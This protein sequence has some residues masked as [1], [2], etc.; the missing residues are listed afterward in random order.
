MDYRDIIKQ[1]LK[2]VS[3]S[4]YAKLTDKQLHRYDSYEFRETVIKNGKSMLGKKLSEKAKQNMSNAQKNRTVNDNTKKKISKKL[5]GRKLPKETCEK[6]SKSRTG[7]K[8]SETVLQTLKE[9]QQKKCVKVSQ[10][11]L[12]GNWIKDW[13]GLK[14]A[15]ES[16][17]MKNGR[18]IQLVC[19]YYRDGLTK[20][21]KQCKG[22]IWKYTVI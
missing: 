9:A 11:N 3:D 20:G 10:F 22:F 16:F 5:L 12:D 19:N 18:A 7:R 4:K 13:N 6:M 8:L 21:S 17:G 1:E 2:K 15:G 14:E